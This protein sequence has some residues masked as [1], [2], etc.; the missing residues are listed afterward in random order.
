[1][2][3]KWGNMVIFSKNKDDFVWFRGWC[4]HVPD[5]EGEMVPVFSEDP[6]DA[7]QFLHSD[8]AKA[9]SQQIRD[10]FGLD[11]NVCPAFTMYS[12]TGKRLLNAIFSK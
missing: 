3:N 11:T 7:M 9:V 4:T 6:R 2:S 12:D 10:T 1:M 8:K 5:R